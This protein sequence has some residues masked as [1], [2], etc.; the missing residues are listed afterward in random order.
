MARTPGPVRI[1]D[2]KLVSPN[3]HSIASFMYRASVG[4][5]QHLDPD[6]VIANREHAALAWNHHD[7]LV[8]VLE[9]A[10]NCLAPALQHVGNDREIDERASAMFMEAIRVAKITRNALEAV[11]LDREDD[12]AQP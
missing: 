6:E 5:S 8:A 3:G 4:S 10:H 9:A 2:G 11:H 1:R 7:R 12:D